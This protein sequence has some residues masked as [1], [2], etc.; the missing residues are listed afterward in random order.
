MRDFFYQHF[1]QNFRSTKLAN[2]TFCSPKIIFDSHR[3]LGDVWKF[4]HRN[5]YL[6]SLRYDLSRICTID[7]AWEILN[8]NFHFNEMRFLHFIDPPYTLEHR[9]L[10][11]ALEYFYDG[12]NSIITYFNFLWI[13]SVDWAQSLPFI[14]CNS[15]C[16]NTSTQKITPIFTGIDWLP[17][18]WPIRT[19][20][21]GKSSEI[22][23]SKSRTINSKSG[24]RSH[25]HFLS[26]KFFEWLSR[27]HF[28]A[29]YFEYILEIYSNAKKD[30]IDSIHHSRNVGEFF[31]ADQIYIRDIELNNH[32]RHRIYWAEF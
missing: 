22:S 11:N 31:T 15:T 16:E 26:Y 14:N 5:E 4:F 29:I 10:T 7:F 24:H 6:H 13:E 18:Y 27:W 12:F 28:D 2:D 3:H 19:I 23:D 1:P 30:S 25:R 17:V 9:S 8:E 32:M 21:I 20:I